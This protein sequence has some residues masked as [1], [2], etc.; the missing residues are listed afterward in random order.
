[1]GGFKKIIKI[2]LLIPVIYF[3]IIVANFSIAYI[4]K[5]GNE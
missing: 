4:Q 5:T 3:G 2:I 1:M